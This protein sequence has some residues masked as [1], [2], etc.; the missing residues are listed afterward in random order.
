M[1]RSPMGTISLGWTMWSS[2]ASQGMHSSVTSDSSR[3]LHLT[4]SVP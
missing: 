2:R 3:W 1:T 4:Q